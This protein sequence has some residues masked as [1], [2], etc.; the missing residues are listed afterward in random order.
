[1]SVW[2]LRLTAS[3]RRSLDRLP[4]KAAAAAVESLLGPLLQEPRRVGKPL[5]RSPTGY[6]SARR[7]E[8]RVIYSLDDAVGAVNVV[9]IGHRSRV[10]GRR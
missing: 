9:R 7:G 10:Y 2:S 1:M 5:T 3:A 4:A 6:W 8:Y